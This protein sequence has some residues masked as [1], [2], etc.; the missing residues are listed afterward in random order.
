MIPT[1]TRTRRAGSTTWPWTR[2]RQTL[3][4][5]RLE[6]PHRLQEALRDHPS[7]KWCQ[8]AEL[9][10]AS[11]ELLYRHVRATLEEVDLGFAGRRGERDPIHHAIAAL[12]PDDPLETRITDRGLWLLLDGGGKAVGRL[13][14]SFRP[15]AGMRCRAAS[16]LAVV[17]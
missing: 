9:P 16:V 6:G 15:P 12:S 11:P 10:P 4:L 1:R 5:A 13:A 7:V 3:A 8:P 17:A 14:K 2:A